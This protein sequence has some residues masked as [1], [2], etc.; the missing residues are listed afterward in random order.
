[1]V[2]PFMCCLPSAEVDSDMEINR[3]QHK[4]LRIMAPQDPFPHTFESLV[5]KSEIIHLCVNFFWADPL[6]HE[7]GPYIASWPELWTLALGKASL[8]CTP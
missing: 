1:M 4:T 7:N 6:P 8:N 5:I 3:G 2:P